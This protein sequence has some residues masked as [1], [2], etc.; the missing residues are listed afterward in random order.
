MFPVLLPDIVKIPK[1]CSKISESKRKFE[2]YLYSV[3]DETNLSCYN[4]LS[5]NIVCNSDNFLMAN[6]SLGT[7]SNTF[8]KSKYA[9]I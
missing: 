6:L 2:D 4:V 3:L 1:N 8:L 5:L 9:P 7:T